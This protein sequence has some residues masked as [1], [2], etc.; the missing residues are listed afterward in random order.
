[1]ACFALSEYIAIVSIRFDMRP[2]FLHG[3]VEGPLGGLIRLATGGVRDF[4]KG[5]GLY[6]LV[7]DFTVY[8]HRLLDVSKMLRHSVYTYR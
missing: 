3:G 8:Q 4:F 6:G 1:M 7:L 5:H 2:H